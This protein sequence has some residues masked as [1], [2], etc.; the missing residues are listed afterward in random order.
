MTYWL[1]NE[2]TLQ[3]MRAGAEKVTDY[4]AFF[5]RAPENLG[6]V[7]MTVDDQGIA[8]I[9]VKGVLT[10]EPD[11]LAMMFGQGN[12]T[13][14]ALRDA[15][16]KAA[17]DTRV[18]RAELHVDSPGGTIA[19]LFDTLASLETFDKPLDAYV[20]NMAASAAYAIVSQADSI[21]ATNPAASFGSV[22]VVATFYTDPEQV[23]VTSSNA[24]N[25]RPDPQTAEGEKA[26]RAE[27]DDL[28]ELFIESIAAGRGTT[29]KNV[30]A[31]FGRGG[32]LVAS[33][34]EAAGMIDSVQGAQPKE[35]QTKV[36]NMTE[37]VA[38]TLDQLK[39]TYP[40][41]VKAI[42]AAERARAEM[43]L[44]LAAESGLY[45]DAI[46]AVKA[47]AEV[48]PADTIKHMKA[49]T[50][51]SAIEAREEDDSETPQGPAPSGSGAPSGDGDMN[52]LI[53][54]EIEA[55]NEER[56]TNV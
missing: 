13:Y 1:I 28:E 53:A 49:A 45:D 34:A 47:G 38:M 22:G 44:S 17:G 55:M 19:G 33:K 12:A 2:N 8:R 35:P 43:H 21:V 16:T 42:I 9:E 48:T 40:E 51:K 18:K 29:P 4:S 46:E 24:P 41:H 5:E 14:T 52:A 36:I 3:A 15:L 6:G 23:S 25:K 20:D 7:P 26:I 27:L 11:M 10:P 54:A 32:M 37:P 31:S 56:F 30:A 39:A 50:A